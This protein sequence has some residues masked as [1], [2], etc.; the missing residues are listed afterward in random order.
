MIAELCV[1]LCIYP[2]FNNFRPTFCFIFAY[3]S[4]R[5]FFGSPWFTDLD[6]QNFFVVI[7]I[8]LVKFHPATATEQT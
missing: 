7:R 8:F 6:E 1:I 4:T 3:F 5:L 2:S